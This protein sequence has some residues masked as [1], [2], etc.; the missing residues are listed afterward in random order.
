MKTY[1]IRYSKDAIQDLDHVWDDVYE[2]SKNY[3]IA[4]KYVDDLMNKI[5]EK[6]VFPRSGIPLLYGDLFTGFYSVNFKKYKAFYRVKDG[7]IDV[8]RIIMSKRDYMKI[9][10]DDEN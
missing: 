3:D 1:P 6:A 9:I 4:D 5:S 2:A 10:F 8:V 7:Y